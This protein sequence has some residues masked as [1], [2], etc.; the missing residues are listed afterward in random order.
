MEMQQVEIRVRGQMDRGWSD[1]FDNLTIIHP[2]QG[3]SILTGFIRDQAELRG[4]LCRLADLGLELTS[5]YARPRELADFQEQEVM[6]RR[7]RR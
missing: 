5:F 1:W 3:E 7:K 4:V 2:P 6:S